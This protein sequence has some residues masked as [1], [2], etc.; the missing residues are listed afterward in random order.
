MDDEEL[1]ELEL[2]TRS[3]TS[4]SIVTVSVP[5]PLSTTAVMRA[6]CPA[7]PAFDAQR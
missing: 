5:S 7:S 2:L 1:L 3:A 6:G 4:S